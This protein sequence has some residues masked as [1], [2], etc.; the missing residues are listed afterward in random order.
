MKLDENHLL[1]LAAVVEA[2]SVTEGA[3]LI[4]SS[5]PA[6]SRVLSLLGYLGSIAQSF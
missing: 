3:A 2:G 1:C 5:Q 6:V 4:G